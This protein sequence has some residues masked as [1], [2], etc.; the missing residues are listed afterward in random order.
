M[1]MS[2]D[3][4]RGAELREQ[5]PEPL[6]EAQVEFLSVWDTLVESVGQEAKHV[7]CLRAGVTT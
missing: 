6:T 4:Q 3:L 7:K 2:A 5:L 1:G